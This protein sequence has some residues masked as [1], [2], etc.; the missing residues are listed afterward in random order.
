[1]AT[2]GKYNMVLILLLICSYLSQGF[3]CGSKDEFRPSDDVYPFK[4]HSLPY[5]KY[6]LMPVLT[7]DIL[8]AHHDHHHQS[9][10][11]KMNAY[12]EKTPDFQDKTLVELINE[13]KNDEHLQMF[14]GGTYNHYFYWW[15]LTSQKNSSPEPQGALLE[16]IN[17]EWGSFATFKE[18]FEKSSR[19]LFGSGYTWLCVNSDSKLEIRNTVNQINPLMGVDGSLCYPVL[20]SDIWEHAYYL[21]YKWDKT[22][23]FS[24][25]WKIIDWSIV[26]MFYEKYASNLQ[27]VPL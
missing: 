7:A 22:T 18:E 16:E 2:N 5:P 24:S 11:D 13:A 25:F 12:I 20:T 9:Y 8:S 10:V 15:V 21:K 6:F 4:L 14:A 23:Y 17:K 27:P 26:E 19:M 3:E 1:M